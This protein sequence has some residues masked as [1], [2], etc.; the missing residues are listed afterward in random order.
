MVL[1]FGELFIS[2]VHSIL[3]IWYKLIV[4]F[5]NKFAEE[6][7]PIS[8]VLAIASYRGRI[9]KRHPEKKRVTEKVRERER[10]RERER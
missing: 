6:C 9:R 7:R 3:L 4:F 5:R 10:E 1:G 2:L 8:Y